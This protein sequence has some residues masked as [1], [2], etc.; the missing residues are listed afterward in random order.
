[1]RAG[2]RSKTS[3]LLN[4]EFKEPIAALA[5]PPP[6]IIATFAFASTDNKVSKAR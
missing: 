4:F 6:P 2:L 1:M 5:V 3:T